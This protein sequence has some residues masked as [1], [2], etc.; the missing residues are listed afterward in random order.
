MK[1]IIIFSPCIIVVMIFLITVHP[2]CAGGQEREAAPE[3]SMNDLQGVNQSLS[4]YRGKVV[5]INFWASWCPECVEELPSLNTLYE[6]YKVKRVVVLGIA[7]DRKRDSV[8]P[9][10]KRAG[11]TYPILLNTAGVAL[12]KQYRVIG[13]PSTVVIDRNGI[14][15][16]RLIGRTDFGSPAF[17]NK[18][19]SLIDPAINRR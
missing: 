19:E 9:L 6:K 16:E 7:T 4:E 3:F 10:L 13:L 15:I 5:I 11:V 14:I 17:T 18:I 12:L 1:G 8:D 2:R